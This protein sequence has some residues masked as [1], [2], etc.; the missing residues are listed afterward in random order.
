MG[1]EADLPWSVICILQC[2][3]PSLHQ[4]SSTHTMWWNV[5]R[6]LL[7]LQ[8]QQEDYQKWFPK[9]NNLKPPLSLSVVVFSPT[10]SFTFK[11][12][13]KILNICN[14]NSFQI[15]TFGIKSPHQ[16]RKFSKIIQTSHHKMLFLVVQNPNKSVLLLHRLSGI[17]SDAFSS[18]W[19][20]VS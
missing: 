7:L 11:S 5:S 13:C 1:I 18:T 4:F 2:D 3:I 10:S 19:R 14:C 12:L 16:E 8:P 15:F 17:Y 6:T 9:T 20:T